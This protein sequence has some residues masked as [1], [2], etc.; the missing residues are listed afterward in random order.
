MPFFDNSLV[1]K[2]PKM[3]NRTSAGSVQVT[4]SVT[5][6]EDVV[7]AIVEQCQNNDLRRRTDKIVG[8]VDEMF[9]D[10]VHLFGNMLLLKQVVVRLMK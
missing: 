4:T 8:V 9:G 10:I 6:F 2:M 3:K 1:R 7:N 5:G